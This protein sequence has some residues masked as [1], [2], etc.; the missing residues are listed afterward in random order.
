MDDAK[1]LE[2]ERFELLKRVEDWLE[3]PMVALGFV[4]LALLIAE[5]VWGTSSLF[6]G[7]GTIIWIMFILDFA[8][9][10]TLAPHKL[11]Y[12]RH[13]LLTLVALFIPYPR[14]AHL[15]D[16]PRCPRASLG[17]HRTKPPPRAGSH[18][19]QPGDARAFRHYGSS[20]FRL[21]GGTNDDCDLCRS[22]RDVRLR[23][24]GGGGRA[25]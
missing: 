21:R 1:V 10:L 23:A 12:L 11:R 15:S 7:L 19:P 18:L 16:H 24:G 8:L 14:T 17:A 2:F 4:W 13:N 9:K 25:S 5:F 3:T 6:E 20:R 22:S